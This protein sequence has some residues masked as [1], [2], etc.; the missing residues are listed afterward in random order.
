M[1]FSSPIFLF[2]FLPIALAIYFASPK[3]L[4]NAVLFAI[5][6]GFYIWAEQHYV[7][8]LLVS[9][10]FNYSA[11]RALAYVERPR[12]RSLIVTLAVVGNL[13][14]LYYLKYFNW[15]VAQFNPLLAEWGLKP[16][17]PTR[18]HLPL[19]VSF[20]TFQAM[21]YVIDVSRRA[22][23]P[24]KNFIRFGLYVFLFPHLIAGPIVRYRD[25]EGQLVRRTHTHWQF[26]EG[27]R[28][29][30]LGIG[31]KAILAAPIA[32][33][34]DAI[35]MLPP[36]E[37]SAGLAWLGAFYYALQIFLDFS[38]YSDMAIGLG[39][40][41]GFDFLEN[42]NYPY[43]ARS[44]TD[45]WRRWH[46]SLSSWFRDYVYIPLGGNRGGALKTYRNLMIIFLLCG[47][48]HG[49]SWNFLVWGA[50]HG[51]FLIVE[52]LGLG[53]FLKRLPAALQHGYT[54]VAVMLGW[55]FFRCLTLTD[56]AEYLGAMF[57]GGSA[58]YSVVDFVD[59][60][61]LLTLPLAVLA[62]VPFLPWL[63]ARVG[64]WAERRPRIAPQFAS[65]LGI[66][67]LGVVFVL[68]AAK[69]LAETYSPFIYF[70]F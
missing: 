60:E 14:I 21:S 66:V 8:I 43:V 47:F 17:D 16:I 11:A 68:G 62:C 58:R 54:I 5:S 25:I 70:R 36:G 26:A 35:F 27:V 40:M 12:N 15:T 30:I 52:R 3:P 65:L 24:Q 44:V 28:R 4:R 61:V 42:F 33:R 56:A 13:A 67:G 9:L 23:E 51:G 50:I 63:T 1:V 7:L 69:L 19:G 34:A 29:L 22:V 31:K 41:F 38:A 6:I 46:I 55:V 20:F 37:L 39:K 57:G 48:W 53:Q 59:R 10:V 49:A 2:W 45:F 32:E 18:A 64:E